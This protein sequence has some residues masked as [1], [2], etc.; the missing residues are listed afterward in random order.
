M[1]EI[2]RLDSVITVNGFFRTYNA[3]HNAHYVELFGTMEDDEIVKLDYLLSDIYGDMPLMR[4]YADMND[5]VINRIVDN[6]DSLYYET[7]KR[8]KNAIAGG[9]ISDYGAPYIERTQRSEQRNNI[10]NATS[11]TTDKNQVYAF[12]DVEN[13]SNDNLSTSSGK[14][15]VTDNRTVERTDTISRSGALLPTDVAKSQIDFSKNEVFLELVFTDIIETVC[16]N[17][18]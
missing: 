14:N 10:T 12:D 13:A 17:V 6:C 4:K 7:W 2:K 3:T 5:G 1:N 18:L 16:V 9:S 8:Y 11:A 15:D